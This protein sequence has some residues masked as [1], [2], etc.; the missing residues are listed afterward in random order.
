MEE[1]DLKELLQGQSSQP[2]RRGWRCPDEV[3]LASY[4]DHRLESS[5]HESIAKHLATCDFC[6]GQ[7]TFLLR[8]QDWPDPDEVPVDVLRR[9][10]NLVPRQSG[11]TTTWGWRWVAASAT[12]AGV[13]LLVVFV[14]FRSPTK[15]PVNPRSEPLIA[16]HQPDI[17]PLGQTSPSVA[18]PAQGPSVTKPRS[19]EPATPVIRGGNQDLLPRIV[20]PRNGATLRRGELDF[21]W[22]P[23]AD[24]SFYDLRLVTADG[25]LVKEAK[26]ED[27]HLQIADDVQLVP[28]GKYFVSIRA[29]VRGGKTVKSS[30]VSFRISER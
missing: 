2:L 6:L 26:T 10:R 17:L 25:E 13:V 14:A 3:Q 20:F 1:K 12:V 22:Q 19:F 21:R 24:T 5:A 28:G 7:V 15:P 8:V 16:Q 30:I 23:V 18:R 27:T 9:A 29:H 11:R 4:V